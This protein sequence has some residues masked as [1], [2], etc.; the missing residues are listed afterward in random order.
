MAIKEEATNQK[1]IDAL[2]S[3]A[4][5]TDTTTTGAIIDTADYDNGVYFAIGCSAW[6]DGAYAL[7]IED[8]DN[9]ALSDAAVIPDAQLVYPAM[10]SLG[11][12]IAEG[13]PFE[14]Q[15]IFGNKRYVRA[16]IVST[17]TSS[18]ATLQVVA[19]VNPELVPVAQ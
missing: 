4:I 17:G 6:T 16:S 9:A 1:V 13:S 14:K 5:S 10:P 2:T 19:V 18:G 8:G 7:K 15:G 12:A 3:Q 11:A